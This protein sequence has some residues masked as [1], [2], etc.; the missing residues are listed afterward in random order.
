MVTSLSTGVFC[1][2]VY[3]LYSRRVADGKIGVLKAVHACNRFLLDKLLELSSVAK[4]A[5]R[6]D[7]ETDAYSYDEDSDIEDDEFDCVGNNFVTA[8]GKRQDSGGKGSLTD[9][10]GKGYAVPDFAAKTK[11]GPLVKVFGGAK[12]DGPGPCFPRCSPKS[13][14]RLAAKLHVD[15]LKTRAKKE[16]ERQLSAT[17]IV[18]EVFSRFSSSYPEILSMELDFLYKNATM[19]Q[20]MPAIRD[21][22]RRVTDGQ[23]AH[24]EHALDNMFTKLS[25]MLVKMNTIKRG[26]KSA[27][28]APNIGFSNGS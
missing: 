16:I 17:N 9:L 13:M 24:A 6:V 23:M 12:L 7:Y 8:E 14:Y 3:W 19:S 27:N 4:T 2:S 25:L 15:Q 26:A 20:V 10:S 5:Q 18:E 22:L 21:K 1:D 28:N 11:A